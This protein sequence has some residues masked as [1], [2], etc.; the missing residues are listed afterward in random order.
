MFTK[1]ITKQIETFVKTSRER[2]PER[3]SAE[4][5]EDLLAGNVEWSQP[6]R[7][8]TVES[9]DRCCARVWNAGSGGQ[10]IKAKSNGTDF[11]KNCHKKHSECP[12]AATFR[13][14]G[15][16]KG[17][18]WGRFDDQ[19]PIQGADGKGVAILW[20]AEEAKETV[21]TFLEEGG[22]WH[23]YCTERQFRTGD[24]DAAPNSNVPRR[25]KQKKSPKKSSVRVKTPK[26]RCQND[27]NRKKI[28]EA[29]VALY[30]E[31]QKFPKTTAQYLIDAG[32]DVGVAATKIQAMTQDEW[33]SWCDGKEFENEKHGVDQF[34]NF[35]K[36]LTGQMFIGTVGHIC[37]E[38]WKE[39]SDD[40]KTPYEIAYHKEKTEKEDAADMPAPKKEP[41]T[42]KQTKKKKK[43]KVKAPPPPPV[44][45][46]SDS[47]VDAT[48][49][50]NILFEGK[51][52]T[53][54]IDD[55]NTAWSGEGE[56]L[57]DYDEKT[58]TIE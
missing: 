39:I 50:S 11:C 49:V 12:T 1:G 17:L 37:A 4:V 26:K 5:L 29:V 40:V 24:W 42:T 31:T 54:Y 43:I 28:Q 38:I 52:I 32:L 58:N 55:E 34:G 13:D 30:E 33:S 20:N 47:E 9:G 23:P 53:A 10:C 2:N 44:D 22:N 6:R 15:S 51:R 27:G 16:H 36:P 7:V 41:N 56:E 46:D 14:D 25:K 18:F 19:L 21:R 48:E 57:G 35:T 45:E 8:S 3:S